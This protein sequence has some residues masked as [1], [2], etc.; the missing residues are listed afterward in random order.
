MTSRLKYLH[1]IPLSCALSLGAC[2]SIEIPH[3]F[4]TGYKYHG[5]EFNYPAP[6]QSNVVST[7]ERQTMGPE[8]MQQFRMA[9]IDL[10]GALTE[11]AGLPPKPVFVKQPD[12]F[13]PFYVSLDN[14][15]RDAMRQRGYAIASYPQGAYAFI[16]EASLANTAVGPGNVD[17]TL[18]VF[19]GLGPGSKMLTKE[20]GQYFIQGAEELL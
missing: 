20:R 7:T 6:E 10:L 14:A 1:L 13:S 15:L 8:Q 3:M 11:R 18:R 16:Y 2:N 5:K 17:I 12:S 19:N 4:P 9:A